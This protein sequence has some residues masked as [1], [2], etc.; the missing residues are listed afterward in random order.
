MVVVS[1]LGEDPIAHPFSRIFVSLGGLLASVSLLVA[2]LPPR[3]IRER[4]AAAQ[5]R[6]G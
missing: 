3:R 6:I 1:A 2:F 4:L 5:P